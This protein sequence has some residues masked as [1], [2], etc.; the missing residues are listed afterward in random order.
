MPLFMLMQDTVVDIK[1]LVLPVVMLP[2]LPATLMLLL[3]PATVPLLLQ[4]PL[5]MVL[6]M[7]ETADTITTTTLSR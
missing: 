1:L 7:V 6:K 4:L 2:P 3:L 5:N